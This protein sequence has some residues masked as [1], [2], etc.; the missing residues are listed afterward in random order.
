[1]TTF[2]E[3]LLSKGTTPAELRAYA[4]RSAKMAEQGRRD[5][6][7]LRAAFE[8]AR[9][10]GDGRVTAADLR[11]PRWYPPYAVLWHLPTL[12]PETHPKDAPVK[13]YGM[14]AVARRRAQKRDY[15]RRKR[16]QARK[17]G[18]TE[19]RTGF[20]AAVKVKAAAVSAAFAVPVV[21]A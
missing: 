8:W 11:S 3:I 6:E 17:L 14:D 1:M 13:T 2:G 9:R 5:D 12:I 20:V 19:T 21:L 18:V 7:R 10:P 16:E 15:M 4:L